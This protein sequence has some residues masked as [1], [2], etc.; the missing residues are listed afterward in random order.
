MKQTPRPKNKT[1]I[2]FAAATVIALTLCLL[3]SCLKSSPDI[4]TGGREQEELNIIIPETVSEQDRDDSET[5]QTELQTEEESTSAENATQ[6]DPIAETTQTDYRFRTKKQLEQHFE[7]HGDEFN[8]QYKT[9][10]EYESG[11]SAVANSPEALHKL[12]K[13][14]GDDVYYIEKTN[15]FVIVSADGYLRTYFKPNAGKAYF[16]RQ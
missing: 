2:F 9:A 8:G 5:A 7:K 12:E 16:D 13:E 10:K 15:E 11:A 4:R 14:D 3:S 1:I 6:A